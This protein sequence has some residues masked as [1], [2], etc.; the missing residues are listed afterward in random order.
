MT[1]NQGVGILHSITVYQGKFR[2]GP[3]HRK[4]LVHVNVFLLST[5]FSFAFP[6]FRCHC[7]CE[8]SLVFFLQK[9]GPD[10]GYDEGPKPLTDI[11]GSEKA[12]SQLLFIWELFL[13]S[14]PFLPLQPGVCNEGYHH[15]HLSK[16]KNQLLGM[17]TSGLWVKNTDVMEL[18]MTLRPRLLS[19]S[20]TT[21]QASNC[22]L[23]AF[24]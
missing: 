8:D 6:G 11:V 16:D 2:L 15:P 1:F 23:Q 19:K 22:D 12:L 17:G 4:Q 5:S 21:C 14:S 18:T 7:N 3:L 24:S 20:E 9:G 10:R 13:Y